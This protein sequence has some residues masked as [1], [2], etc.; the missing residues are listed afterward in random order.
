SFVTEKIWDPVANKFG[1]ATFIFGTIATSL[2]GMLLAV[3]IGVGIAIFLVEVAPRPLRAPVAFLIELLAAIPSV[4]YGLWG[5]FVLAPLVR[6][7]IAPALTATLGFLP[8]FQ[9]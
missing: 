1:A 8:F 4:V 5:L 9:G 3:P 6:E 7:V 2:I